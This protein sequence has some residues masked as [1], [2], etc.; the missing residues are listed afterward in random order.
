MSRQP[1]GIACVIDT[2]CRL[3]RARTPSVYPQSPINDALHLNIQ[4]Y[5][6]SPAEGIPETPHGADVSCS[7]SPR[8]WRG[9]RRR[10]S[11]WRKP[12]W[13][14]ELP[15][16]TMLTCKPA[17]IRP[18]CSC[19]PAT[20]TLGLPLLA[21]CGLHPDRGHMPLPPPR[22]LPSTSAICWILK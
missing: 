1:S 19:G 2:H 4:T 13:R 14:S 18:L 9:G 21:S 20:A 17:C 6:T 16:G 7:F 5:L 22:Q 11:R 12:P 10:C 8:L 15:S 3:W